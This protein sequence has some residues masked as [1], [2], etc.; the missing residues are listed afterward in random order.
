MKLSTHSNPTHAPTLIDIFGHRVGG[1]PT[2][3]QPVFTV[4]CTSGT[5]SAL[6][7]FDAGDV[8]VADKRVFPRYRQWVVIQYWDGSRGIIQ[9]RG[10]L[11]EGTRVAGTVIKSIRVKNVGGAGHE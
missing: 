10:R 2:S 9:Y 7:R 4:K 8:L 11:P 6:H 1:Y 3:K 5:A